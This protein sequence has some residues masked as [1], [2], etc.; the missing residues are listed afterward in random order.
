MSTAL[1]SRQAAGERFASLHDIDACLGTPHAQVGDARVSDTRVGDIRVYIQPIGLVS[2]ADAAAATL[3]Q[4]ALPLAGGPLAFTTARVWVRTANDT[5]DNSSGRLVGALITAP[6]LAVW[7]TRREQTSAL[8][9]RLTAPRPPFHRSPAAAHDQ[10]VTI[11]PMMM[12]PM[13]MGIVNVTPDSFSDGGKFADPMAAI[14]HG[15]ALAQAGAGILDVGGESTRPGATPV[16]VDEELRRVLPVVDAL[17]AAGLTVSI[18]TRRAAVMRAAVAAGAAMVNDVT[19]LRD[20][21]ESMAT[22]AAAGVP[23]VLM[24][25]RGRP[26]TM[27]D[28]PVYSDAAL[29]IY[30]ALADRVAACRAAGIDRIAVDPGI[31]FGK[32]LDHNVQLLAAL[33]LFQGIGCPVVLGVS[34]K[35]FIGRVDPGA[36]ADRRLAG[37]LAAAVAGI[38]QGAQIVRVHDVAETMQAVRI[39]RAISAA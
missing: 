36:P 16:T 27:Q 15:H 6:E 21:S 10:P 14:A 9:H 12:E 13:I 28:D 7:A 5:A 11:E 32:N 33:G 22:V 38:N 2:G 17:A 24:H 39:W 23:V 20:D 8:L 26:Q 3:Q 25:M 19:A 35:S 29:D 1:Q 18:D 4:R 30:D 31:G 37:S 34:R